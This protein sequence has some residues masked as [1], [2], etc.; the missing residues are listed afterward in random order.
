[1]NHRIKHS[2]RRRSLRHES[3]RYT[4]IS[5]LSQKQLACRCVYE[6]TAHQSLVFHEDT[7]ISIHSILLQVLR[8]R[9][10]RACTAD[11][12][13]QPENHKHQSCQQTR[14]SPTLIPTGQCCGIKRIPDS[15]SMIIASLLKLFVVVVEEGGHRGGG[16]RAYRTAGH[17][18]AHQGA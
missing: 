11:R 14:P 13:T 5:R 4:S 1:M 12:C 17:E 16:A 2:L 10:D 8:D 18:R 9:A 6:K 7:F 15:D 3:N